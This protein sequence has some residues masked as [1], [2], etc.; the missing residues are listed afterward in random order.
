MNRLK[1]S[2]SLTMLLAAVLLLTSCKK[3]EISPRNYYANSL[4]MTPAQ[5]VPASTSTTASGT[6]QATYDAK[7]NL[8]SY[9]LTWTGLSG[10]PT[11]ISLRGLADAGQTAIGP[12]PS[13]VAQ[14]FTS[15]IPTGATSV[16]SSYTGNLYADE[17]SIHEI[18][19][20]ANKF[21]FVITTVARPTGELRGQLI[22]TP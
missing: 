18:D 9:T 22:L 19:L 14:V 6:I 5:M 20:L 17:I 21:Y 2:G 16:A 3:D 4:P 10:A 7:T 15:G 12:Y 8:L 11:S 1:L 13:G